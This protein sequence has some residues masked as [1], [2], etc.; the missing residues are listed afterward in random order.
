MKKWRKQGWGTKLMCW[1]II[2]SFIVGPFSPYT[3]NINTKEPSLPLS[4][5]PS[6][7]VKETQAEATDYSFEITLYN[8]T[9]QDQED[10][11]VPIPIKLE[12]YVQA[13]LLDSP[14]DI[15]FKDDDGGN[16]DDYLYFF[17]DPQR[18][19]LDNYW[20]DYKTAVFKGGGLGWDGHGGPTLFYVRVPSIP[21]ECTLED[22]SN[23]SDCKIYIHF[24]DSN[25]IAYTYNDP[26]KVFDYFED[27]SVKGGIPECALYD[28][29]YGEGV[30]VYPDTAYYN[31]YVVENS[32]YYWGDRDASWGDF[33]NASYKELYGGY[34]H[35]IPKAIEDIG[36]I[37]AY[38]RMEY[39][40]LQN[41]A[42]GW[43]VDATGRYD[44]GCWDH[45]PKPS[46]NGLAYTTMTFD[47]DDYCSDD[48]NSPLGGLNTFTTV[49]FF[50]LKPVSQH[51]RILFSIIAWLWDP[52]LGGDVPTPIA[53]LYVED[54]QKICFKARD[55][56][57]ICSNE[58]NPKLNDNHWHMLA[59]KRRGNRVEIWLDA[60]SDPIAEGNIS[61][62]SAITNAEG[63]SLGYEENSING[64]LD[65]I[66]IFSKWLSE[67]ELETISEVLWI[68]LW[69]WEIKIDYS[70]LGPGARSHCGGDCNQYLDS[71][72][73]LTDVRRC[74]EAITTNGTC[75]TF[76]DT[77]KEAKGIVRVVDFAAFTHMRLKNPTTD[78]YPD[79]EN[80]I[81]FDPTDNPTRTTN[82]DTSIEDPTGTICFPTDRT[83]NFRMERGVRLERGNAL[84]LKKTG[85]GHDA[86]FGPGHLLITGTAERAEIL[87]ERK[88][89]EHKWKFDWSRC[90]A[91][92]NRLIKWGFLAEP[93]LF[94]DCSDIKERISGWWRYTYL[95]DFFG[96][97][98]AAGVGF[99]LGRYG[100]NQ[101]YCY[102]D[103]SSKRHR[104]ETCK[105]DDDGDR[106]LIFSDCIRGLVADGPTGWSGRDRHW[107]WGV[108]Q[109]GLVSGEVTL[110]DRDI[111]RINLGHNYIDGG[112]RAG[113]YN[114]H[115]EASKYRIKKSDDS[116]YYYDELFNSNL[117]ITY[118]DE[119]GN[120]KTWRIDLNNKSLKLAFVNVDHWA[121]LYIKYVG[122][123]PYKH[124]IFARIKQDADILYGDETQNPRPGDNTYENYPLSQKEVVST[125]GERIEK[126][127]YDYM[128][129]P[130]K[131]K[132]FQFSF[133]NNNE[134]L[135]D[136]FEITSGNCQ[137]WHIRYDKKENGSYSGD[138]NSSPPQGTAEFQP[139]EKR[140][141]KMVI[142]PDASTVF[143]GGY[144][145]NLLTFTSTDLDLMKDTY[146]AK[147]NCNTPIAC[148]W[149]YYIP[150]TVYNGSGQTLNDFVLRIELDPS[151]FPA[152]A[153]ADGGDIRF[154]YGGN[155]AVIPFYIQHWDA[156]NKKAII[157]V[158][159]PELAPGNN[160]IKMWYGNENAV[161]ASDPDEV[162]YFWD[163][164]E[165][166]PVGTVTE[167]T[168][169]SN[170]KSGTIERNGQKIWS[171]A[172][173][174]KYPAAPNIP[175]YVK[176]VDD[177]VRKV[178]DHDIKAH[179]AV[180]IQ[181]CDYGNIKSNFSSWLTK[182]VREAWIYMENV[183]DD[184]RMNTRINEGG[185]YNPFT[186][187]YGGWL[188]SMNQLCKVCNW[189]TWQYNDHHLWS[190]YLTGIWEYLDENGTPRGWEE[191]RWYFTRF[192]WNTELPFPKYWF[193]VDK[194]GDGDFDDEGELFTAEEG[195]L[196]FG[197]NSADPGALYQYIEFMAGSTGYKNCTRLTVDDVL[198]RPFGWLDANGNYHEPTYTIGSET[199]NPAYSPIRTLTQPKI[200]P[201]L[202]NGRQIYLQ[203]DMKV[204][205]WIGDLYA[206]DADC[207]FGGD[208]AC[209][210][211]IPNDCCD[212]TGQTCDKEN[213]ITLSIW[214]KV[215][216]NDG[217]EQPAGFGYHLMQARAGDNNRVKIADANWKNSGRYIWTAL[218]M[219]GDN[220]I[221]KGDITKDSQS[222]RGDAVAFGLGDWDC[223]REC[224]QDCESACIQA[225]DDQHI[226]HDCDDDNGCYD[227]CIDSCPEDPDTGEKDQSCVQ[228]C[229][230]QYKD[231]EYDL[232]VN[233]CP[234][235]CD[236]CCAND[237][238]G[239]CNNPYLT[240]KTCSDFC[241]QNCSENTSK[242]QEAMEVGDDFANLVKFVRGQYVSGYNRSS[243]R[244]MDA[245]YGDNDGIP[246]QNE[247]WKL[248]DIMHSLPVVIG[249][250]AMAYADETY[251]EFAHQHAGRDMVVYFGS[252]D[253]MIHA[254][255]IAR[256]DEDDKRY[257]GD[258]QATELWAFIPN[259]VL[260]KLKYT[261]S[262]NHQ[263]T[264]DG[265]LKALDVKIDN[266]WRTV[267][268]GTLRGGGGAIFA[269]DVT[270]PH[271]PKLLWEINENYPPAN[272]TDLFEKLGQTWSRPF[273]G[274][275]C[276]DAND[277]GIC[278]DGRWIIAIG[279][280]FATDPLKQ[281]EKKAYLA[282]IDIA[283]GSI[284]KLV[285]VSDKENNVTTD[286]TGMLD[287]NGFI[288]KLYFG[289][290]YGAV[291]RIDLTTKENVDDFLNKT[292]L[293]QADMFFK[294]E[295]YDTSTINT[296]NY[297]Q[298]PKRPITAPL[299]I[300]AGENNVLWIY[301]GTGKYDYYGEHF[302]LTVGSDNYPYQ[303][304]Y[305][306]KDD[307][308]RTTPYTDNDLVDV[309]NGTGNDNQQSWYLELGHT[310]EL[311]KALTGEIDQD[312]VDNCKN[313]G[314]EEDYCK[315]I[316]AKVTDSE[317][318]RHE[319]VL[320]KPT[321]F[322][323]VVL[324]TTFTPADSVCGGGTARFYAVQYD[325]G[326]VK[327][328]VF[329][330]AGDNTNI[331]SLALPD[332]K[333]VPAT[334]LV[335]SGKK[336]G[337][338]VTTGIT[339]SSTGE[340]IKLPLDIQI[341]EF[342]IL[343]WREIK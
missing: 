273:I 10:V 57:P 69:H 246:E 109:T 64:D 231:N 218:D 49:M 188:F 67:E 238:A 30:G 120:E 338:L 92:E 244:D 63:F 79:T 206:F 315:E 307:N 203:T 275:L 296:N 1:L 75:V 289:D 111:V 110:W 248:G 44:M 225:C 229:L 115:L 98:P 317:K 83:S 312:C 60:R 154:T 116:V 185:F 321:V 34:M 20:R 90:G 2:W 78:Y 325:T 94:W 267:L 293:T 288:K 7:Q 168:D 112:W 291:W 107:R 241:S 99:V 199:E 253:G 74:N 18:Y 56:S 176:I 157:Y 12:L 121:P 254:V 16:G 102:S 13:G 104:P 21:K 54:D 105:E 269:L 290:R 9:G 31:Q 260:P 82:C 330:V 50:K 243:S 46:E 198:I 209:S 53:Y 124:G 284:I 257:K 336:G 197:N 252:N 77:D 152:K 87:D 292:Q 331:R 38:W 125:E 342:N 134:Y 129:D 255:R 101:Y 137:G 142:Y 174:Y 181:S 309:T 334:P 265:Y 256:Y 201:P 221:G 222:D 17:I 191:G 326:G 29:C 80:L 158:K 186:E 311:D 234:A 335:Y 271:T 239:D 66:L 226:D 108:G 163:D 179:G 295:D 68:N 242:L 86:L 299:A 196:I 223:V 52:D 266:S 224:K 277:N 155:D 25:S 182:G 280:G 14:N 233:A 106:V 85:D 103:I 272:Q 167:V 279:S 11:I 302:G 210:D 4:F 8:T 236:E 313:K 328:G 304:F 123:G 314:N 95:A 161:S 297:N 285:K 258:R 192:V 270:N 204:W 341:D 88:N 332:T 250:P 208:C 148:D 5:F 91:M 180:Q 143:S 171:A 219:N 84:V 26:R 114:V 235:S 177:R 93:F 308:T 150:I 337:R 319:R 97:P 278:K 140:D 281:T 22:A 215:T 230:N 303:R 27:F 166:Y 217:N 24:E 23:R 70:K 126:Y 187:L 62:P 327:A 301:F 33:R 190:R 32:E 127:I 47:E 164:F 184:E 48:L 286:I 113:G 320:T 232:C 282:L 119:E 147:V 160:T 318:D 130:D 305:G 146:M 6:F 322:A 45:P 144:C 100:A 132:Y 306:L 298:L 36:S 237:C 316:C 324:F 294:P 340:I 156:T 159:I 264:V 151:H 247:Q 128:Y 259:A 195:D 249:P 251:E 263:Y 189:G 40:G 42:G 118:Y 339:T 323:G 141:Y 261:T 72:P 136:T 175:F 310:S 58:F 61:N 170:K 19:G 117:S 28:K 133:E 329:Q 55:D 227:T 89:Y 173:G 162:F 3:L 76:P 15:Y 96:V 200:T 205:Q 145:S 287:F 214:G 59:L 138:Y 165:S 149:Q 216:D 212:A 81:D 333:G 262:N 207:L 37:V 41:G 183:G 240:G 228:D 245:I 43:L 71:L 268:I 178:G 51:K 194:N 211:N 39:G 202:F 65:E 220:K 300:A 172:T 276:E 35:G 131:F 153:K 213:K 122:V 283:D 274:R 193:Y 135:K 139:S 343:L 169:Y 73:G